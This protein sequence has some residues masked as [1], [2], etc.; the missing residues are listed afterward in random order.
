MTPRHIALTLCALISSPFCG[1]AAET[2]TFERPDADAYVL[3]SQSDK[4][5]GAEASFQVRRSDNRK[6]SRIGYV[7]FALDGRLTGPVQKAT[8]T[9][10]L[11]SLFKD[12]KNPGTINVYGWT[13]TD[14]DEAS[15]TDDNA[16]WK[17]SEAAKPPAGVQLLGSFDVPAVGGAQGGAAFSFT[18]SALA[19][20]LE[21][22]R[23][24]GITKVTF[25]VVEQTVSSSVVTF[26]TKENPSFPS[27]SLKVEIAK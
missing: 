18:S 9:F 8:L 4:N 17:S 15:L 20:F 14:W 24:S 12:R 11:G 23:K 26:I 2:I 21:N 10:T 5:F 3:S 1:I 6:F 25:I 27:T 19:E 16:F 7:R 22:A 13:G